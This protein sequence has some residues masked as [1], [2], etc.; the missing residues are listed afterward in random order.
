MNTEYINEEALDL[1]IEKHIR[2]VGDFT[3]GAD[4]PLNDFLC[5]FASD[6]MQKNYGKTYL[7]FIQNEIVAYYTLKAGSIIITD[8]EPV[9]IPLVEIARLA[10][11]YDLQRNGLGKYM[12]Y[13]CILPKIRNTA[14]NIAIYSIMVFVL[15][16]DQGAVKFYESIGFAKAGDDVQKNVDHFNEDCELYIL[17]L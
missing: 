13:N 2:S 1:N 3:C 11:S 9:S 14:E 15:P 10:V 17:K 12:F 7:L 16:A 6:Y 5:S 4:H 8:D